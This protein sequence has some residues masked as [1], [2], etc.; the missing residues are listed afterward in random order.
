[1]FHRSLFKAYIVSFL[2]LV[3]CLLPGS[4]F[5]STG[6]EWVSLDKV[7]HLIMY[8]PLAWTLAYGFRLQSRYAKW[9]EKALLYTFILA[10]VYGALVELLQFALTPDR[11]AELWDFVADVAG[12]VLGLLTYRIGERLILF[13]NRIWD[14]NITK[15]SGIV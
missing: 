7:I 3:V 12:V 4:T 8:V 15:G 11:A 1:M 14:R 10:S 2:I 6:V 5:P 9:Q 13:W